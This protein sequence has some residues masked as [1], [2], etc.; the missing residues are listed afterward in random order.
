MPNNVHYPAPSA[1][2]YLYIPLGKNRR[3]FVQRFGNYSA[4]ID[5]KMKNWLR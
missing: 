2:A 3:L 1:N 5:R 4:L